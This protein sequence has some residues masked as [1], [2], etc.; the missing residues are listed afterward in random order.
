MTFWLQ[1]MAVTM[2]NVNG[3][4]HGDDGGLKEGEGERDGDRDLPYSI[5]NGKPNFRLTSEPCSCYINL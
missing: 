3:S 5:N 2:E 4:A 1:L